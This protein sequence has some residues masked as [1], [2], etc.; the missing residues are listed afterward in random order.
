MRKTIYIL[1]CRRAFS[2]IIEDVALKIFPGGKPPDLQFILAPYACLISYSLPT[3]C[4]LST[5]CTV[6]IV[7][8]KFYMTYALTLTRSS[9]PP[10]IG[11]MSVIGALAYDFVF[12]IG[13]QEER[14]DDIA[15]SSLRER[16][17]EFE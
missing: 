10:P 4:L 8:C 7:Q 14:R 3:T 1:L 2:D 15:C 11:K 13:L 6:E 16:A 5:P 17:Y 12:S 9:P